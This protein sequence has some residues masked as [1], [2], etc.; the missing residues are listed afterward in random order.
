[1]SIRFALPV[2]I[3]AAL[4]LGA[5][6]KKDEETEVAEAPPPEP[7]AA[8][9]TTASAEA[10][11]DEVASYPN[12]VAQG[13]TVKL[14]QSFTVYKAADRSSPV[15]SRLGVGTLVNLKSSYA[16]WM[17]IEWPSGVGQLSPGWIELKSIND[18]RVAQSTTP[19][20]AASAAPSASAAASAAP[21]AEASAAPS[22]SAAASAAPSAEASA[23]PTATAAASAAPSA[24]VLKPKITIMPKKPVLGGK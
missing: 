24:T 2:V 21:S 7:T 12:E 15:L 9:T 22:A 19:A 20:T 8:P 16:N 17:K 1:M 13:G 3:A 14:L 23:A 4:A 6:C 11:A 10:P 5:G 18:S